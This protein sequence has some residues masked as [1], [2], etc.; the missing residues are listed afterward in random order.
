MYCFKIKHLIMRRHTPSV[1]FLVVAMLATGLFAIVHADDGYNLW[2]RYEPLECGEKT[3]ALRQILG[4][5]R[6]ELGCP[7]M[8]AA[9]EE[10]TLGLDGMIGAERDGAP[11]VFLGTLK[12]LPEEITRQLPEEVAGLGQDGFWMG[13]L[14]QGGSRHVVIAGNDSRG[15][16]YGAFALL[17]AIQ[18]GIFSE[19]LALTEEPGIDVRMLNHWDNLNRTVERGQ[20]GQSLWEWFQ[21][22]DYVSPRYR[23]YARANASVGINATALTNVNANALVLTEPFLRKAE[24]IAA[25]LRPYGMRVFLTARF[26]APIE[27]GGLPSA[28]PLNPDVQQWW[29]EKA[30]EIYR[31]I[32]DF[33][34]F[35]VKAN[36]EGQPGPQ[37]Y[38]RTHAEGA[39]MMAEALAPHGGIVIWRAFVY[40][41]HVEVD[42]HMQAVDEFVPL[43]GQFL[44]NVVV[45]VKNGAIDFMPREPFHP[46]FGAMPKTPLALELQIAQE[47]LGGAIHLAYLAPLFSEALQWDT[48][49]AGEGSTVAKV[50]DGSLHGHKLSVIA[51]VANTGSD[52]NWTGHPLAAA[53]WYAFGRLAWD[54]DLCSELIAREW[55][56]QTFGSR[57]TVLASLV[58]ML[59]ESREAVVDYSMPL[60]LHHIMAEGHHYGP[61]PWV[62]QGRA[63]WT[64]VYYH[65]ATGHGVGFDRTASGSGALLQ[66]SEPI[67]KLWGNPETIPSNLLL[68]F[69]H[70]P[71]DHRMPDGFSLWESLGRHY[72]AGVDTVHE[73]LSTWE[74]L[75]GQVPDQTHVH[76]ASLLKRQHRE[77]IE[78][79]DSCL[80]YF[81]TF[82]RLPWPEAADPALHDLD[83][84]KSNQLYHVPGDPADQ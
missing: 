35:L 22:P 79:K 68:W 17:R 10:L 14:A 62:D 67:Q 21:L 69:H 73:W 77:A 53:N 26:S 8:S 71:W 54:P 18:T 63:D 83:H 61:G 38:G 34:G 45:Q 3:A 75:R 81:Q 5:I 31:I 6:S 20:S 84:Y 43:D 59:M 58:P 36:S 47:Y 60:G 74:G 32:P 40:S 42:R 30:D 12:Q 78:Y 48:W 57:E 13:T 2:L 25:E 9:T 80:L 64:S 65:R 37:D 49:V 19:D 28:D 1:L 16:L 66:Y 55:V 4:P 33:G 51:G 44:P 39:N 29:L 72:Q 76:V 27:L 70:M 23:D 56:K 52:R 15:L 11:A 41:H 50:I 46:L 82:S 24:A 7:I